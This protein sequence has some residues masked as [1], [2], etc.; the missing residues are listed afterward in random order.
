[1]S[2]SR[3]A[4]SQ[5]SYYPQTSMPTKPALRRAIWVNALLGGSLCAFLAYQRCSEIQVGRAID[6]LHRERHD[7][8]DI[9]ILVRR[10][11]A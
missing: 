1:M 5:F 6:F 7:M 9:V 2:A 10:H 8:G 3:V 11:D 4:T